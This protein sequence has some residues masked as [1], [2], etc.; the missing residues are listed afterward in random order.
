MFVSIVVCTHSLDNLQNLIDAVDSLL[1]Q[2]H[3]E[4]E[5]IIVVDDNKGLYERIAKIYD[6]QGNVKIML[7]EE[8]LGAFGAG[9]V[10][11]EAAQGDVIAFLDDDAV[12]EK[13]WIRNLVDIYEKSDAISVGGKILPIWLSEKPDYFPEELGWLVGI[14]HE[15]FAEEKVTEVRNTFGPNMSFR[16][17]VFENIGLLNEKL[18]F[19]KGGTTYMQGAE[20]E[21]ALRMKNK[22]GKGVIYNPEAVVYHKIPPSKTRPRILLR[23]AFYQGYS[24]ALMKR[25][26]PS[27]DTLAT[28]ESYLKDLL[29][30]YIPRRV[31]AI[32]SSNSV[33]EMK[34]LSF[35]A[36]TI[37]SVGLGFLYGYVKM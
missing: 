31:K 14:T 37:I 11:V 6:T 3:K 35:L 17:E 10:G 1:N 13:R 28:E 8:S 29:S 27:P 24:K 12:G 25:R 5:I 32:F 36:I 34:Q 33:K 23:R 7:T 18:G 19:A 20:P 21:F 9:N 15:G 26:S 4:I 30:K 22:L 2:T 16:R